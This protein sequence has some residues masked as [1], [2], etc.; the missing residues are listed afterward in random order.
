VSTEK[1][2]RVFMTSSGGNSPRRS[3]DAVIDGPFQ[4]HF[5]KWCVAER[6]A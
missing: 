4:G 2:A 1:R 6:G 5:G 3:P